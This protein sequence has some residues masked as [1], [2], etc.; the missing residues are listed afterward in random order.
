MIFCGG[1]EAAL[2]VAELAASG[3]AQA[4]RDGQ[5]AAGGS[6]AEQQAG[7]PRRRTWLDRDIGYITAPRYQ[8]TNSSEPMP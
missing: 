8:G 5:E 1:C 2:P 4:G 7:K 3:C 6:G